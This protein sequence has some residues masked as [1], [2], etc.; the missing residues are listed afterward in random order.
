MRYFVCHIIFYL[1]V[2][3]LL[4]TFYLWFLFLPLVTYHYLLA[5]SP[6]LLSSSSMLSMIMLL[7]NGNGQD[8]VCVFWYNFLK[9]YQMHQLAIWH[10]SEH[11]DVIL[12]M[13][14]Y[15]K[16]F[17][18]FFFNAFVI[19]ICGVFH[20]EFNV[21]F[22]FPGN[23]VSLNLTNHVLIWKSTFLQHQALLINIVITKFICAHRY[24]F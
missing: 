7:L 5:I 21:Q 18:A 23:D 13:T 3:E 22:V 20:F 19:C 1:H 10:H 15:A 8:L 6:L 14:F 11:T 2:K 17:S 12:T 16:I 9:T 4:D 24:F